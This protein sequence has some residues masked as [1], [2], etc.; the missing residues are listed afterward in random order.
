MFP[1][2]FKQMF[3]LQLFFNNIKQRFLNVSLVFEYSIIMATLQNITIIIHFS[4][5]IR[6]I[7]IPPI[8]GGT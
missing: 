7:F 4:S 5:N 8:E 3:F 6:V 1:E 2:I